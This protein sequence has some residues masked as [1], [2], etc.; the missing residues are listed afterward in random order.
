MKNQQDIGF[1]DHSM[2][3]WRS[4][5]L[6]VV[7][8]LVVLLPSIQQKGNDSQRKIENYFL[9]HKVS[10]RCQRKRLFL[11]KSDV[12]GIARKEPFYRWHSWALWLCQWANSSFL[13]FLSQV[14]CWA[15]SIWFESQILTSASKKGTSQ[16][17]NRNYSTPLGRQAWPSRYSDKL[18]L[19]SN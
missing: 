9:S 2:G 14:S 7:L 17:N 12:E 15:R 10:Y 19:P 1:R 5:A 8:H 11:T 6:L 13:E 16:S 3:L 18:V 4:Q